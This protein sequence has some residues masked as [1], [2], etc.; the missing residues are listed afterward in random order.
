[1]RTVASITCKMTK[2]ISDLERHAMK[3]EK[4]RV[5][6]E[7]KAAMANNEAL[8]AAKIAAKLQG[9]FG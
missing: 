4:K 3:Q 5:K 1:M 6:L 9:I 2:M 7:A 8:T